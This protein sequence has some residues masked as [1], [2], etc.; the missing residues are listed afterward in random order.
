MYRDDEDAYR[1]VETGGGAPV[2]SYSRRVTASVGE[3]RA[4]G[5][6]GETPVRRSR[7]ATNEVVSRSQAEDNE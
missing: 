6:R 2:A 1:E 4:R 5:K 7:R 3:K